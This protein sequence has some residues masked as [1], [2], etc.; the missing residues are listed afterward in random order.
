[1]SKRDAHRW[2]YRQMRETPPPLPNW[3][4]VAIVVGGVAADCVE[5]AGSALMDIKDLLTLLGSLGGWLI[6]FGMWYVNSRTP[7]LDGNDNDQKY[8]ESKCG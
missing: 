6:A 7:G 4:I 1:M 3:A 5:T 8:C 2:A